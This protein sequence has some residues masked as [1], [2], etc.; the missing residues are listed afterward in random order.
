MRP[1]KVIVVAIALVAASCA[2]TA[3]SDA[4][5]AFWQGALPASLD[6]SPFRAE[7]AGR[8]ETSL[9]AETLVPAACVEE[10]AAEVT[11]IL[12][13]DVGVDGLYDLGVTPGD[14]SA[15]GSDSFFDSLP[16][17]T[18][19]RV[20]AA[21][22]ACDGLALRLSPQIPGVSYA[23][24]SCLVDRLSASGFFEKGFPSSERLAGD[25]TAAAT[26]A[27]A[28]AA[29]LDPNEQEAYD[30]WSA[31]RLATSVPVELSVVAC[32]SIDPAPFSAALGFDIDGF[33]PSVIK[34]DIQRPVACAYGD[35]DGNDPWVML[36]VATQDSQREVYEAYRSPIPDIAEVW[37]DLTEILEYAGVLFIATGGNVEW[38]DG[39]VTATFEGGNTSAANTAGD[40]LLMVSAGP[41]SG[42]PPL[43]RSHLAGAVQALAA[44]L[45]LS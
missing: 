14:V 32:P 26:F 29:C 10:T 38:L 9:G 35:P 17:A 25:T 4:D 19:G 16:D 39:A 45:A 30:A 11:G 34:T 6:D 43:S 42:G 31:Q 37:T 21:V 23:S 28:E 41:G 8:L 1:G 18:K 12:F 20:V 22:A 27:S 7:V 5:P 33:E 24:F 40:Y 36:Y 13:A 2:G 15:V 3:A 44:I